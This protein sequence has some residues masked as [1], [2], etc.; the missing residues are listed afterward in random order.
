M[1]FGMSA[2]T[3]LAVGVAG[4]ALLSGMGGDAPS[5]DPLIGQSAMG[6]TKIAADTLQWYKDKDAE[7][8]PFRDEATQIALRQARTQADTADK[9]NLRADET[10]D[11]TKSTFR[12]LE[13]RI[14]TDALGYDT[15]ARRNAEAAQAQAD[16]GTAA[17]AGRA[18]LV[19]EIQSRGGD[20]NSGN[21]TASLA[22][23]GIREAAIKAG[24]G[25][26][27]RKNVEAVGAAK[28]ADAANLGRGIATSNA[29][30][31]QL[32]L[33]AGNSAVSNAQAPINIDAARG[34]QMAQGAGT[35]ISGNSS[36]GNLLL[37]QYNA[38]A[39]AS[40]ADDALYGSLGNVAG[41][42]ASAYFM[43][44]SD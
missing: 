40:R 32:G 16:I 1:S 19:R 39:D 3:A 2:G 10:Y 33:Q 43:K 28:L 26:Q 8:K 14:A 27:A 6:N 30:T 31:T 20:I 41:Q 7:M 12:P 17:D 25:N 42:A 15:A 11:Y 5:P 9:Q 44:A 29:T 21:F 13:Q 23:A 35:A 18:N 34:S 37:G 4:G 38:Q 22:N 36:A 24:A